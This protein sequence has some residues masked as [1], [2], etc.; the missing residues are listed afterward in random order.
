MEFNETSSK[1]IELFK[2]VADLFIAY[3][4]YVNDQFQGQ[5]VNQVHNYSE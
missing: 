5:Q 3:L 4:N 2:A 1:P